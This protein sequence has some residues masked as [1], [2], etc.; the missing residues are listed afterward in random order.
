MCRWSHPFDVEMTGNTQNFLAVPVR[1]TK[2]AG[3]GVG[4]GA[5][6]RKVTTLLQSAGPAWELQGLRVARQIKHF[7][8]YAYPCAQQSAARNPTQQ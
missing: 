2:L 1:K 7:A 5:Y 6:L 8:E 4:R 3:E